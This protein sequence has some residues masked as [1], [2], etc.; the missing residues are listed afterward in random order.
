VTLAKKESGHEKV[1][2]QDHIGGD[3]TRP[4]IGLGFR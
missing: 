2:A 1:E 4:A 3:S